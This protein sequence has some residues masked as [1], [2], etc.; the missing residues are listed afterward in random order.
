M[1]TIKSSL[2]AGLRW[3]P[4]GIIVFLMIFTLIG[5]Q[6]SFEEL[7]SPTLH[8]EDGNVIF[9]IFY[10]GHELKNIFTF[11]G[12]YIHTLPQALGYVIQ[13]FP[14]NAIAH[15]YVGISLVIKS[16]SCF[17][18]YR[19]IGHIFKSESL[20]WYVLL[21][22]SILP[23]AGHEFSVSLTYQIWN[24]LL[25]PFLLLFLPIPRK[26]VLRVLYVIVVILMIWS[27]PGSIL[28]IPLHGFR[29]LKEKAHRVE[30]GLFILA[31]GAYVLFGVKSGSPNFSGLQYFFEIFSDRVV[32]DSLLGLGARLYLQYLEITGWLAAFIL[33]ALSLRLF[34]S[35]KVIRREEKEF[36]LTLCCIALS[37][38]LISL[39]GRSDFNWK[40]YYH[41]GG[42]I[43]YVYVARI[44]MVALVLIAL[45]YQFRNTR[46]LHGVCLGVLA[47]FFYA[48]SGSFIYYKTNIEVSKRVAGFMH[49]LSQKKS[50]CN[51]QEKIFLYLNHEEPYFS[52][53]PGYW[54]IKASVCP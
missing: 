32:I 24:F 21:A 50:R 33:A 19:A 28:L 34:L 49:L 54:R 20:A 22:V 37:M 9:T 47:V 26:L 12:G 14:V 4:R 1:D 29:F 31:T 48:Q 2:S 25:I 7:F 42:G 17:L 5:L 35:W 36:I 23:L 15:I 11:H 41:M 44:F 40:L 13:F 27:N 46:I 3:P 52:Y 38:V 30:Y 8:D 43:R 18:I 53:T 6:N 16:L 10:N 51:P 45:F 39:M